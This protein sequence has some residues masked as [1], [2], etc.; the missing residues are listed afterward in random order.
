[1][2]EFTLG[3]PIPMSLG[4]S[5]PG[6]SVRGQSHGLSVISPVAPG[7]DTTP[8]V[9]ANVDPT[10]GTQLPSRAAPI[11]FDVTDV[12]PGVQVVI[13]TVKYA[14]RPETQVVYN[15]SD[16]VTPFN[17]AGS[18]VTAITNGY[19]FQVTPENQWL[20]DIDQFFV[21]AIDIAGNVEGLP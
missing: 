5:I 20:G 11:S 16:F 13:V 21:Y 17:S 8:P 18:Q 10:S 15:G 9:I 12:D 19:H 1:M 14:T 4:E 7:S 2:A 3:S 6:P